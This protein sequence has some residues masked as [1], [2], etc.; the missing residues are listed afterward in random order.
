MDSNEEYTQRQFFERNEI[1]L[2]LGLENEMKR[3]EPNHN[4][5]DWYAEMYMPASVKAQEEYR[6]RN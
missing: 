4:Y 1:P 5:L 3:I 6:N 2:G